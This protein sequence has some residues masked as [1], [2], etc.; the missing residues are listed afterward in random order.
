LKALVSRLHGVCLLHL[1]T[2][3]QVLFGNA[4]ILEDQRCGVGSTDAELAFEPDELHARRL[5]RHDEGLDAAASG[6]LVERRPY[7]DEPA[8]EGRGGLTRGAEDLGAV[9][10]PLV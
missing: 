6:A 10:H 3:E 5:R 2:P 7:H 9:E 1:R 8:V 4:A